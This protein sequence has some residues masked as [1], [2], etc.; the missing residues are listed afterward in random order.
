MAGLP[1]LMSSMRHL[2]GLSVSCGPMPGDGPRRAPCGARARG[3]ATGR[4]PGNADRVS[5]VFGGWADP[6]PETAGKGPTRRVLLAV[7]THPADPG[8][9]TDSGG[10]PDAPTAGTAV[11]P[12]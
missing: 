6:G 8:P 10:I 4:A 3:I 12:R 2:L 7:I 9:G 11:Y 1:A 5:I